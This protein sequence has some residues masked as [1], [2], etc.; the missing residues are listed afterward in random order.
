MKL[1]DSLTQKLPNLGGWP[2]GADECYWHCG[3]SVLN[4]Y[5]DGMYVQSPAI[6]TEGLIY[7]GDENGESVS[8]EEYEAALAASKAEWN[9]EG[10]PPVGFECELLNAVEFYTHSGSTDFDEGTTVVVGG[11][12]NFGLGDFVAVKVKGTNCITDINPCF[13]RPIRPE[14]DKKREKGVVALATADPK[15][16]PFAYGEKMSNGELIG[17]AWYDLYDAIAAGKVPGIKLED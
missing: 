2:E 14:A 17:S 8:K 6:K 13:L 12:V 11:T 16:A 7:A 9:G 4:F 3:F 10:L 15:V 1:I 5:H